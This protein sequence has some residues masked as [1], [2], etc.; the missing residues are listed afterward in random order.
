MNW[1][2]ICE[3][4]GRLDEAIAAYETAMRLEPAMTGPRT[5]LTSVM[6]RSMQ[7]APPQLQSQ[8]TLRIKELRAEEMVLLGRDAKL[9]PANPDIQYRY[10]LSLYLNGKYDESLRYLQRAVELAPDNPQFQL[11]VRLLME[12]LESTPSASAAP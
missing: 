2:M 7:Q 9:A 5:N 4:Q 8:L 3:Q 12:K 10:G 6:E 1:G 11:A